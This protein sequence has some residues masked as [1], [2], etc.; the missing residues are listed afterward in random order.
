MLD[1][2]EMAQRVLSELE[3][4][5]DQNVFSML[6]TVIAPNGDT[7]QL[8]EF[9]AAL[10]ALVERDYVLMGYEGF[11]PRSPEQLSKEES[12]EMIASLPEWFIFDEAER[13]WSLGKGSYNTVRY[14]AIHSTE[15]GRNKAFEILDR[16]GYQWWRED[17]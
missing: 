9:R 11:I 8:A 16:R 4:I 7:A 3:E 1:L 14:P 13:L 2:T 15:G 5:W 10:T 17:K 12:L 6:N